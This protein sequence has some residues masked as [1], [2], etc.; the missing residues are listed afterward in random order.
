MLFELNDYVRLYWVA[1]YLVREEFFPGDK[2][3]TFFLDKSPNLWASDVPGKQISIGKM[4]FGK[5]IKEIYL[6]LTYYSVRKTNIIEID[7][8]FLVAVFNKIGCVISIEQRQEQGLTIDQVPKAQLRLFNEKYDFFLKQYPDIAKATHSSLKKIHAKIEE[9]KQTSHVK[10]HLEHKENPTNFEESTQPKTQSFPILLNL[11]PQLHDKVIGREDDLVHLQNTISTAERIVVLNGLGGIGKTTL[12]KEFL[13][14][15]KYHYRHIA[16]VSITA[17]DRED[18]QESMDNFASAFA[19]DV[20]LVEEGLKLQFTTEKPVIEKFKIIMYALQNLSGPNLLVIDNAEGSIKNFRETLPIPPHWHILVTSRGNLS[21]FDPVILDNLKQ[22]AAV[23][24]FKTWY[25]NESDTN[26]IYALLEEIDYHTLTIELLAKTLTSSLGFLSIRDLIERLKSKNLNDELLQDSISTAHGTQETTLLNHL[27]ITFKLVKLTQRE[28]YVL[29]CFY[30]LPPDYYSAEWIATL[31]DVENEVL[32][33]NAFKSLHQKGWLQFDSKKFH[34]HRLIQQVIY[35]ALSPGL[36]VV[37]PYIKLLSANTWHFNNS[38]IHSKAVYIPYAAFLISQLSEYWKDSRELTSLCINLSILYSQ[39]TDDAKAEPIVDRLIDIYLKRLQTQDVSD[40][41]YSRDK[42]A[43]A[44]CCKLK[45]S[46]AKHHGRHNDVWHFLNKALNIWRDIKGIPQEIYLISYQNALTFLGDC[47]WDINGTDDAGPAYLESL[48]L[49]EKL[50]E[51]D[52]TKYLHEL[53]S[54]LLSVARFFLGCGKYN[55]AKAYADRVE[56][57]ARF[58]IEKDI[59]YGVELADGLSLSAQIHF[60]ITKDIEA[61]IPKFQESIDLYRSFSKLNEDVYAYRF[62]ELYCAFGNKLVET[63]CFD[64]AE[65]QYENARVLVAKLYDKDRLGFR[66]NYALISGCLARTLTAQRKDG[67][68]HFDLAQSLISEI[69]EDGQNLQMLFY[70]NNDGIAV[71]YMQKE[72]YQTAADY[73]EKSNE[74]YYVNVFQGDCK[75]K[76]ISNL[77]MLASCYTSLNEFELAAARQADHYNFCTDMF[78]QGSMAGAVLLDSAVLLTRNYSE[79]G[80]RKLKEEMIVKSFII[81]HFYAELTP[82]DELYVTL[83]DELSALYG[84]GFEDWFDSEVAP[85]LV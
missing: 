7:D 72:D 11:I 36:E 22:E 85:S 44:I 75:F 14:T 48:R 16:W 39:S 13:H 1:Y 50:Y 40:E 83:R 65:I 62:T 58:A 46:I 76:L 18:L 61:V 52:Q 79:T 8:I 34:M 20:V 5:A 30:F 23:R 81:M 47:C 49:R 4:L 6:N 38:E 80:E 15:N 25:P 78:E 35:Y 60:E 51:I 77:Y 37:E 19:Q 3:I 43:L 64:L 69:I 71:H 63:E 68:N 67:L 45:A 53:L 31:F 70:E 24:L 56:K 2:W 57:K 9:A 54:G 21:G 82:E 29:E 41:Y 59:L 17:S 42:H 26:E 10:S 84:P 55:D 32:F 74:F 27:L 33:K 28:L 12:A 73:F 66:F